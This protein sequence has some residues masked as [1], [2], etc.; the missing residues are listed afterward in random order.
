MPLL[1][2]V[3]LIMDSVCSIPRTRVT[4]SLRGD[5]IRKLVRAHRSAVRVT[6]VRNA[7]D[8][9]GLE[10]MCAR[11]KRNT[12][13]TVQYKYICRQKRKVYNQCRDVIVNMF[14]DWWLG[15]RPC[16]ILTLTVD[17]PSAQWRTMG[18]H[19]MPNQAKLTDFP[20]IA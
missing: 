11:G 12:Y 6:Q 10:Y 17:I 16:S 2:Q 20:R 3:D 8:V 15:P 5:V 7:S 19:A 14:C 9:V 13:N 18:R 4:S 1:F